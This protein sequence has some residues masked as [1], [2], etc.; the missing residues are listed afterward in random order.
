[1]LGGGTYGKSFLEA[2]LPH[3]YQLGGKVQN[4]LADQYGKDNDY[5][6]FSLGWPT[7]TFRNDQNQPTKK[8]QQNGSFPFL[9]ITA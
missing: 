4:I 1:M 5:H 6:S 8:H 9:S 7:H 3:L 2:N